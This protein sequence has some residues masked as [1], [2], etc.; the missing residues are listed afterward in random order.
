[1]SEIIHQFYINYCGNEEC[2][3]QYFAMNELDTKVVLIYPS[4]KLSFLIPLPAEAKSISEFGVALNFN[5]SYE[6]WE[7]ATALNLSLKNNKIVKYLVDTWGQ[8]TVNL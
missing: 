4:F 1:M 7:W 5:F 6:V 2:K 8:G 3:T